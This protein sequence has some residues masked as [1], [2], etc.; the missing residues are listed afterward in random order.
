MNKRM[1]GPV[2]E[3]GK[4]F[5]PIAMALVAA[6]S[7]GA[8]AP[9]PRPARQGI[10]ARPSP[11][12]GV[13]PCGE[14]ECVE[15]VPSPDP[16]SPCH[17]PDAREECVGPVCSFLNSVVFSSAAPDSAVVGGRYAPVAL[18][19]WEL[20]GYPVLLSS[21]TPGVCALSNGV[22]RFVAPGTCVVAADEGGDTEAPDALQ[23]RQSFEVYR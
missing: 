12:L 14:F 16:N 13:S 3:L 18:G 19:Q 5:V 21:L 8:S 1:V 11:Q 17:V 4:A 10:A 22:L 9:D 15:C 6:S 23:V 2:R 7:I 20:S